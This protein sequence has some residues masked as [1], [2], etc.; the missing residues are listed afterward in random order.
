[1]AATFPSQ[2][3]TADRGTPGQEIDI[4]LRRWAFVQR[5]IVAKNRP[6]MRTFQG[7]RGLIDVSERTG[8]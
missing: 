1:M 6:P 2:H 4:L 7:W 3:G 8:R 5:V